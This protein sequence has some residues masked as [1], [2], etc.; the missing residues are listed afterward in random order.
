MGDDADSLEWTD[1]TSDFDFE[2]SPGGIPLVDPEEDV[3]FSLEHLKVAGSFYYD[4][5]TGDD[6]F[7]VGTASV[8][9]EGF[10]AGFEGNLREELQDSELAEITGLD[11]DEILV[12]RFSASYEVDPAMVQLRDMEIRTAHFLAQA[13]GTVILDR[14]RREA[15]PIQ[16]RLV[17]SDLSPDTEAV[18]QRLEDEGGR[19]LPREGDDIVLNISGTLDEPRIEGFGPF[20]GSDVSG[21]PSIIVVPVGAP[22]D[23]D[24]PFIQDVSDQLANRLFGMLA[25]E[26]HSL[27]M[28]DV[29]SGQLSEI[30]REL[31]ADLLLL[32]A[33]M[34]TGDRVRLMLDLTEAGSE[35]ILWSQT[36][37]GGLGDLS[38]FLDHVEFEIVRSIVAGQ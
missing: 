7:S 13:N 4:L 28:S 14:P 18:I 25:T 23:P 36:Y 2:V 8:L 30:A 33:A 22:E 31:D 29:Y 21:G 27:P 3:R 26:V 20:P 17:I 32:V 10:R 1:A 9:V 19:A 5:D 34:Q 24:A 15:P 11:F 16:A 12:D 37:D 35:T 38:E 6:P